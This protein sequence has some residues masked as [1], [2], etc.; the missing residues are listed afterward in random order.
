LKVFCTLYCLCFI[1]GWTLPGQAEAEEASEI[2][3][4]IFRKRGGYIHGFL[5]VAEQWTDNL[6][7]TPNNTESDFVTFVSPGIRLSLPGTKEELLTVAGSTTAPGGMSF[8]RMNV[9]GGRNFQAYLSYSPEFEFYAEN[10]DQDIST[11]LANGLLSWR[12]RSGLALEL[13]DQFTVGY[14]EYDEGLSISRDEY[15]SNLVGFDVLYPVGSRLDL[16]VDLQNYQIAYDATEDAD[17]DRTDQSLSAYVFYKVRSKSSVFV[18]YQRIDIE[19]DLDSGRIGD[20][21]DQQGLGGFRWDFT[22]KSNGAVK[23]GIGEKEFNDPALETASD[24]VF[25][26]QIEHCFTPKT[27]VSFRGYRRQEETTI[28]TTDYTLTQFVGLGLAQ[29]MTY[30][31][32]A[33]LDLD[34]IIEEY[35]GGVVVAG[36]PRQRDDETYSVTAG[37]NYAPRGWLSFGLEYGYKKRD[38]NFDE[39]DY[40]ANRVLLRITG[41]I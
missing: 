21:V 39:F 14:Q 17:R 22:A 36:D 12:P 41:A 24:I 32:Q 11:H 3:G 7:Y 6:F 18:E 30:R 26:A 38:S 4:D 13:I 34:S 35:K 20:S 1:L 31:I 23:I 25:E 2:S 28:E 37:L 9:G 15:T 10:T 29:Q 40:T 27:S 16:R 5:S 8:G 33:T 19:Y